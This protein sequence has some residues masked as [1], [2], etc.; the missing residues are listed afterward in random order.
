MGP[1]GAPI[2]PS[3]GRAETGRLPS[4]AALQPISDSGYLALVNSS[5]GLSAN[6]DTSKSAHPLA[7]IFLVPSILFFIVGLGIFPGGKAVVYL[8]LVLLS[9][10]I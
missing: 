1:P 10:L 6:R 9:L 5:Y 8:R 2:S 4:A 3:G 7:Q